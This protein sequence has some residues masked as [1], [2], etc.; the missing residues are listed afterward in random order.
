[1]V[2]GPVRFRFVVLKTAASYHVV[3]NRFARNTARAY[4]KVDRCKL[5]ES[6]ATIAME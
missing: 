5:M 6:R 1:M 4:Q 3:A 2:R